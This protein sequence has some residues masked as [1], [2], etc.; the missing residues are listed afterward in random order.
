MQDIGFAVLGGI[1]ENGKNLYLLKI[2]S[3]YFILDTGLKYPNM[4]MR[5][6]DAIIPEYTSLENIKQKIKGI[7]ITSAFETHSG[8]IPYLIQYFKVPIY[9]SDFVIDILKANLEN[10]IN[11]VDVA[12]INFKK[13]NENDEINLEDI[14]INVFRIAH[15]LPETLG[16][17][18]ETSQGYIVYIS[19]MHFLQ[20]KN[21]NF[22][23]NFL[24]LSKLNSKKF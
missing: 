5:G 18:F 8:S 22:Q 17:A 16:L 7:F 21:T 24:A 23:T 14:K 20:S 4:T 3:S 15:F 1:G 13:I 19:E 12:Q 9:A 6:I 10:H 11:N 2:K